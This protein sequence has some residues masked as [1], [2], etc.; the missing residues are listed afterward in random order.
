M[1]NEGVKER[2]VGTTMGLCY[3]THQVLMGAKLERE[4]MV[5]LITLKVTL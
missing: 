2:E 4:I 5:T 1:A 3:G